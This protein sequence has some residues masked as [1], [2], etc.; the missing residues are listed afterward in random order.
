[1][2]ICLLVAFAPKIPV[3]NDVVE[4]FTTLNEATDNSAGLRLLR[5]PAFFNEMNPVSKTVGIGFG[6]FLGFKKHFQ[7]NTPHE[8]DDEYMAS[9]P[10]YLI[11]TGIIGFCLLLL[12]II[13]SLKNKPHKNK[14]IIILLLIICVSSSIAHTPIW[15]LYL[16]FALWGNHLDFNSKYNKNES[17]V[18]N[19][20]FN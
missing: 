12:C 20:S 1:M 6:S 15:V 7:I 8:E 18:Y 4:R 3:V 13:V 10:D 16:S 17:I 19:T 11:S 2:V 9:L 14:D 5:G